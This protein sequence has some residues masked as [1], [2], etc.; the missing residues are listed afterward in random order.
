MGRVLSSCVAVIFD[1]EGFG[2]AIA[3]TVPFTDPSNSSSSIFHFYNV[4]SQHIFDSGGF[5]VRLSLMSLNGEGCAVA[6]S[7][8]RIR[9]VGV[10]DV[11]ADATTD[12]FHVYCFGSYNDRV[13]QA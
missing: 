3:T 12:T 10:A 8:S 5:C 1:W 7:K 11:C 6:S 13:I 2:L 9:N 4:L